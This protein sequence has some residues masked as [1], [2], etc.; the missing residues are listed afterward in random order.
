MV[1]VMAIAFGVFTVV[2]FQR[3]LENEMVTGL[4]TLAQQLASVMERENDERFNVVLTRQQI[5]VFA[6]EYPAGPYYRI[7]SADQEVV[8][9]SSSEIPDEYPT[10]MSRRRGNDRLEVVVAGPAGS[11][12]LVGRSIAN[13]NLQVRQLMLNCVGVAALLLSLMIA[14][15]WMLIGR[16]LRPIARITTAA[17]S[18]TEDSLSKRIDVSEMESE[19]IELSET[20]NRTFARIEEAFDRQAR[21]TSDA[22]H[23]LRT[24]LTVLLARCEHILHADRT[25]EEYRSAV[26]SIER[27]V[28]KLHSVVEGLLILARADANPRT[29]TD[30][31]CELHLIVASVCEFLRPLAAKKE[32]AVETILAPLEIMGDAAHLREIVTNLLDNAI[33]YTHAQGAIHIELCRVDR[34]AVL[35]VLDTGTGISID[36]CKF[37]FDRFFRADP[38]RS[39][40]SAGGT[41]IG[42]AITKSLVEA[43]GGTI[44]V[45]SQLDCGS[46]FRVRF[47]LQ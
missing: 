23:E 14:G 36:D 30:E 37:V 13:E 6:T 44:E 35:T 45:E 40:H 16:A 4:V 39:S 47:P 5:D 29:T 22:S 20:F 12:I 10:S 33:E 21:F 41:G 11:K 43:H 15:G 9:Y 25:N 34:F 8:D 7:W 42:L 27:I 38:A 24:P 17:A 2:P 28:K 46:T 32:I 1:T 31:R 3:A 26:E 18:V 19:L